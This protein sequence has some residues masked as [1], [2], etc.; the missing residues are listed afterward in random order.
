MWECV[1]E[2]GRVCTRE[3]ES[4]SQVKSSLSYTLLTLPTVTV[5]IGTPPQNDKRMEMK[6]EEGKRFDR[7]WGQHVGCNLLVDPVLQ[8]SRVKY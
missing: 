2:R 8:D 7:V 1:R 5:S 3:Q 4:S 6:E